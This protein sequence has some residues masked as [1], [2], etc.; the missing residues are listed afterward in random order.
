M[1]KELI[2]I[3]F[4]VLM[5]SF[6]SFNGVALELYQDRDNIKS[7][8]QN[9]V[10]NT[11]V[12]IVSSKQKEQSVPLVAI[13]PNA[14]RKIKNIFSVAKKQGVLKNFLSS[15][16]TASSTVITRIKTLPIF[17]KFIIQEY[18]VSMYMLISI[19]A[20]IVS[21]VV[22]SIA[23]IIRILQSPSSSIA[24]FILFFISLSLTKC[25]SVQGSENEGN[26]RLYYNDPE[27]MRVLFESSS[28][29]MTDFDSAYFYVY[30]NSRII[31][32]IP[33][34]PSHNDKILQTFP[35][36]MVAIAINSLPIMHIDPE[37]DENSNTFR[38]V[39]VEDIKEYN[40]V[41]SIDKYYVSWPTHLNRIIEGN[42]PIAYTLGG[43]PVL[44]KQ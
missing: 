8:S 28:D 38:F 1:R 19:G 24:I 3:P 15:V 32:A 27:F 14:V 17:L 6:I 39:T 33:L 30:Q 5:F 11:G 36:G 42:I 34:Y 21:M 37:G 40:R 9:A 22:L 18:N 10:N 13:F 44:L 41:F 26:Q 35:R 16:I 7:T 12:V 2:S 43:Y 20:F 29:V 23:V 4:F 31:A 25:N